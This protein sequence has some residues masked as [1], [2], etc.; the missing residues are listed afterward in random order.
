MGTLAA[1]V[2][3]VSL[4][5]GPTLLTAAPV[6]VIPISVKTASGVDASLPFTMFNLEDTLFFRFEVPEASQILSLN[7]VTVTVRARDDGDARDEVGSFEFVLPGS[8]NIFLGLFGTGFDPLLNTTSNYSA[9]VPC[10][11]DV[12]SAIQDNG[13]FRIRV[14]REQ[15]DFIV[16]GV[17]VEIDANLIPEPS[18]FGLLTSGAA[19]LAL[20]LR[21]RRSRLAG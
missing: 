12:L 20:K 17:D 5:F 9:S 13:R 3:F 10:F 14:N 4:A 7:S 8:P 1:R 2:L 19:A 15:G 16:D 6:A 21:R 18:T 11:C